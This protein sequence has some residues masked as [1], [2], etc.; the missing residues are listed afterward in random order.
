MANVRNNHTKWLKSKKGKEL[1]N[2]CKELVIR[3]NSPCV[4][5]EHILLAIWDSKDVYIMF[6]MNESLHEKARKNLELFL[7]ELSDESSNDFRMDNTPFTTRYWEKVDEL[8]NEL[9]MDYSK[10]SEDVLLL[11]LLYEEDSFQ[12]Y[13]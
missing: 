1:A 9:N 5:P 7:D 13:L 10:L 4:M 12:Q 8:V 6:A 3:F 2:R 11:A